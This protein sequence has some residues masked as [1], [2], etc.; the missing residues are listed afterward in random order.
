[1]QVGRL[2]VAVHD[3][4]LVSLVEGARHLA[5]IQRNLACWDGAATS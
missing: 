1:M 3:V 2:E 4:L 5:E